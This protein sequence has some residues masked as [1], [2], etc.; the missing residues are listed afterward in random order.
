MKPFTFLLALFLLLGCQN[1]AEQGYLSENATETDRAGDMSSKD[2]SYGTADNG[3]Q[4]NDGGFQ[5]SSSA[6]DTIQKAQKIIKDGRLDIEV[7]KIQEAKVA[8]D[9]IVKKLNAYYEKETFQ[10]N[11]YESRFDLS[12]RVPAEKFETLV[13]SLEAG[14]NKIV[15]KEIFAKDVTEEYVDL[16]TRLQNNKAYIKRYNE[17]LKSAKTVKDILDIQEKTRYIEEEMDAKIGRINYINDR[18]KYSRLN[19]ELIKKHEYIKEDSRNFGK[20][21]SNAF[22]NGFNLM[23]DFILVL[24]NLWPFILIGLGL[25]LFRKRIRYVFRKKPVK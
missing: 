8:V 22:S 11:S 4:K 17:L 3:Q 10:S 18:V 20:Q 25:F 12:I 1:Q 16:N 23:L 2:E 13:S 7:E 24:F 21:V 5:A 19:V 6:P 14:G 15:F 9:A